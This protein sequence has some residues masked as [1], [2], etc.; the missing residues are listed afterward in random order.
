MT[1]AEFQ[2][3][4]EQ[5]IINIEWETARARW[6]A[7]LLVEREALGKALLLAGQYGVDRQPIEDRLQQIYVELEGD[8]TADRISVHP[9]RSVPMDLIAAAVVRRIYK[10]PNDFPILSVKELPSHEAIAD[11][12]R[13]IAM[14]WSTPNGQAQVDEE[15]RV[16]TP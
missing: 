1:L 14:R 13:A 10:I 3:H 5:G 9:I 2:P 16:M 6:R 12:L 8:V 7:G 11:A 4:V 15:T